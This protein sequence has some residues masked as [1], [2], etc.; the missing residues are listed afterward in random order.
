LDKEREIYRRH[1]N[2][3][4]PA[5]ETNGTSHGNGLGD[6]DYGSTDTYTAVARVQVKAKATNDAMEE[7]ATYWNLLKKNR[8][9]RLY[10]ASYCITHSGEWLTY[11]ASISLAEEFLNDAA[12][13]SRTT[14]SILV[15]VRLL[16]NVLLSPFGG[17]LADG[18]DRRESMIILDILGSFCPLLFLVAMHFRSIPIIYFVTFVQQCVTGLYEPCVSSILPMMVADMPRS[19]DYLKKATTLAGLSWSLFMAVGS[20]LGGLVLTMFGFRAC[21]CKAMFLEHAIIK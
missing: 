5:D 19:D 13:S 8:P 2:M 1:T 3:T 16:P 4:T 20:S 17:I 14:I 21:F 7:E 15:V 6:S 11:I 18:R 9:F 12:A 10:L